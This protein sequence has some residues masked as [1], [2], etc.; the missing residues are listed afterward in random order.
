MSDLGETTGMQNPIFRI[1]N[2]QQTGQNQ[3]GMGQNPMN[4]NANSMQQPN[5]MGMANSMNPQQGMMG[6][7]QMGGMPGMDMSQQQNNQMGNNPM[8]NNPMG[9]TSMSQTGMN[10]MQNMQGM[11]GIGGSKMCTKSR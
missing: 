10:G 5:P 3:Q 4:L 11:Q 9:N 2:S 6:N 8:G 7:N 1:M